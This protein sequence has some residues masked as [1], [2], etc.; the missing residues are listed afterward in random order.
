MHK[1]IRYY[2]TEFHEESRKFWTLLAKK[3]EN[4]YLHPFTAVAV[5]IRSEHFPLSLGYLKK[6][7]VLLNQT[8]H[9]GR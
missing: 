1:G 9:A 8:I 2:I 4:L 6:N 5:M 3:Y 7:V